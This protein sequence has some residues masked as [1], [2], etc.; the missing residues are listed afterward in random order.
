MVSNFSLTALISNISRYIV[1]CVLLYL[2]IS[3]FIIGIFVIFVCSNTPDC[4]IFDRIISILNIMVALINRNC[5]LPRVIIILWKCRSDPNK[6]NVAVVMLIL[7]NGL[8]IINSV[9]T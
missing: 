4:I 3:Y 5:H 2:V 8:R 9:L 7:S 1:I 6:V